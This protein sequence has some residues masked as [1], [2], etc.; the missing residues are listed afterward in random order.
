MQPVGQLLLPIPR[1]LPALLRQEILVDVGKDTASGDRHFPEVPGR[2]V[3][4]ICNNNND[5]NDPDWAI[6]NNNNNNPDCTRRADKLYKARSWLYRTK[7][8]QVSTNKSVLN[9]R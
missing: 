2:S 5:N 9:T 3:I 1:L 7:I 4:A 6:C 8:L